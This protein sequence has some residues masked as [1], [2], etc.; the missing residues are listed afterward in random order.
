[1]WKMDL[2]IYFLENPTTCERQATMECLRV[3]VFNIK[4][5]MIMNTKKII[6]SKKKQQ[7]QSNNFFYEANNK[8][9]F[10]NY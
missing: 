4:R 7:E 6:P 10:T 9:T 5:K 2:I 3:Q 1:M 8:F